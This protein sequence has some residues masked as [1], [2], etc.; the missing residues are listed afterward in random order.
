MGSN[1]GEPLEHL[2]WARR[3]LA[4][5]GEVVGSSSLYQTTPVGGPEGQPDYLNAVV[6][7]EPETPEPE[8]LL[9]QLLGLES[10]RGRERN[11]R[12]GARTLDLDLLTFAREVRESEFL[13]LPHPRMMERAFV[14][15]P[16]CEVVR[17]VAP[18]W[19]HPTTGERAC[20][21][22]TSLSDKGVIRTNLRWY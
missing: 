16:L 21:V 17:E 2:R 3:N 10:Q 18:L 4:S 7:L 9:E 19:R 6:A 11:E 1:L 8:A 22:L 12:W 13:T 5:L 14:L 15:A 20:D